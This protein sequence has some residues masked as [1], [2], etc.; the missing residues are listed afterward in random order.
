MDVLAWLACSK[1]ARIH[2]I[3]AKLDVI[4]VGS[5]DGEGHFLPWCVLPVG[6]HQKRHRIHTISS[7]G[8]D[9]EEQIVSGEAFKIMD[10]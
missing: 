8:F 6:S 2:L 1:G 7:Y 5:E 9:G 10:G 4:T 3:V